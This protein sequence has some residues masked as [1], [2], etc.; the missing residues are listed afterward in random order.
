VPAVAR[1]GGVCSPLGAAPNG[2]RSPSGA[3]C[4][5]ADQCLSGFCNGGVC[6]EP[7]NV[8]G[9]AQKFGP[10]FHGVL[11]PSCNP[12]SG[13]SP[14]CLPPSTATAPAECTAQNSCC[15]TGSPCSDHAQCCTGTCYAAVGKAAGACV[16]VSSNY[17]DHCPY[18]HELQSHHKTDPTTYCTPSPPPC[19]GSSCK[20]VEAVP[21]LTS[22][23]FR[24]LSGDVYCWGKNDQ[25]QLGDGTTTPRADPWTFPIPGLTDAVDLASSM[26]EFCAVRA[27]GNV[28]CWGNGADPHPLAI[29][30]IAQ[31]SMGDNHRCAVTRLGKVL[32]WGKNESGQLGSGSNADSPTPVQVLNLADVAQVSV[33]LHHTC[34]R[35]KSG[36]VYCWGE[37]GKL[38]NGTAN[39]STVPV[40]VTGIT[41]A[42]HVTTGEASCAV[43]ADGLLSCWR[44]LP[45][46]VPGLSGVKHASAAYLIPADSSP[47]V[48]SACAVHDGGNVSCWFFSPTMERLNVTKQA[49]AFDG[50]GKPLMSRPITDATSITTGHWRGCVVKKTG[51]VLCD[52]PELT[53]NGAPPSRGFASALGTRP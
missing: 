29:E 8:M 21:G 31:L 27:T 53:R 20:I 5:F 40:E 10:G 12:A 43:R 17:G 22:Q 28:V 13:V 44:T 14:I 51:E 19:Q 11:T 52:N 18:A 16:D 37:A 26:H 46:V 4:S 7:G 15:D 32:C 33:G 6:S 38:G 3:A 45:A 39:N 1:I 48:S 35:Q 30:G 49:E 25:R 47:P 42:V 36:K 34:A 41:N 24:R 23:C 9:C 50:P 2:P